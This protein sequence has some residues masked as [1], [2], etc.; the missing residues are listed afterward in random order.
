MAHVFWLLMLFY[1][2]YRRLKYSEQSSK[3]ETSQEELSEKLLGTN[4]M[5]HLGV[6]PEKILL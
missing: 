2:N 4:L 1:N 5:T 3:M 6:A